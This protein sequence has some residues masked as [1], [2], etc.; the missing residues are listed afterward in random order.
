MT[1]SVAALEE[2]LGTQEAASFG[3]D[4][5]PVRR[6]ERG[7]A[8]GAPVRA[9]AS[10]RLARLA[11]RA[12]AR[13]LDRRVRRR[14]RP[15]PGDA[16]PTRARALR[17]DRCRDLAARRRARGAR[18]DDPLR[19][20]TDRGRVPLR[21]RV[22]RPAAARRRRRPRRESDGRLAPDGRR[23]RRRCAAWRARRPPP[24]T[25]RLRA[26]SSPSSPRSCASR[27]PRTAGPTRRSSTDR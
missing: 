18:A 19:A 20:R 25:S 1:G 6:P 9:E 17:Q 26:S 23:A 2:R 12:A 22:L 24:P 27:A 14:L 7:R 11:R 4:P 13:R 15:Q 16:P 21:P 8:G 3:V 10:G 5:Y